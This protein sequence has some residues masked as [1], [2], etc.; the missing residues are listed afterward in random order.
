[1]VS[2]HIRFITGL[3][4]KQTDQTNFENTWTSRLSYKVDLNEALV[5][6]H[7]EFSYWYR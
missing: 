6:L 3:V 7:S 5:G 2:T 1:M 4:W